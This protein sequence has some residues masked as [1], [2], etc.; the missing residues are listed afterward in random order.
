MTDGVK[1]IDLP[2]FP[3]EAWTF[4]GERDDEGKEDFYATVAAVFRATNLTASAT[5]NIPFALV[6]KSGKDYDV[7][8]EWENKILF[9]P[10]PK[11]L[12]RLWRL[13]L[14]M[15][16]EAYGFME[17]KKDIGKNLRYIVPTT[18]TPI[19]DNEKGL[20]GFKRTIG[21][22]SKDYPL[23]KNNP[24]FWMWRMDH[25]TE[26][27]PAKATEF[28]AMCAAAGILY[29]SDHFIEAF[30]KRGGIRPTMLVLKGMTTKEKVKDIEH[31]WTQIISGKFRELGKV[32]QGVEATGGLE[33][34]TIGEGVDTLKD[35][36][37]TKSKI[38]DVAMSIGMPLSLLLANSA[39]YATAL[40]EYKEW[41]ENSLA[42]WCDFMAE[43][44]TDKLFKPLGLRFEF[45]PEM[46]DPGQ[47]DEVA[48][49]SAYST[50][51]S[52]G[53]KP[54]VAAQVIGMELPDDIEYEDLDEMQEEKRQQ[55][56]ELAKQSSSDNG[57]EKPNEQVQGQGQKEKVS[58]FIP[59]LDQLHELET[60]RKF[61]FRKFKKGES[62][63]FP[64]EV[65]KLPDDIAENIRC[66]LEL[67]DSE[68][69]IKRAFELKYRSDQP[70][71]ESGRWIDESGNE[72]SIGEKI[73]DNK[74]GTIFKLESADN[75]PKNSLIAVGIGRNKNN[76]Y[77]GISKGD[78]THNR[79]IQSIN[80]NDN[81]DN[82]VRFESF[83]FYE[84][85]KSSLSV[86]I[87][88]AGI[89]IDE[90]FTEEKAMKNIYYAID[91]LINKGLPTDTIITIGRAGEPD[92]D[93]VAGKSINNTA[94]L[95][96]ADAINKACENVA[97][98]NYGD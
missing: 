98:L 16:N 93:I 34:Q 5:A 95:K 13:S 30:F 87:A 55:A 3:N 79:M 82:Y 76:I 6:D 58:K 74:H 52:S 69:A 17:N 43:E 75:L 32:F 26:L 20:I 19:T 25:T 37:L 49:A 2:Q 15:T 31:S 97:V 12:I 70:R 90:N 59:N 78:L 23:G 72:Y 47:E 73:L 35:E 39:N 41:Y 40:V 36:T 88:S 21:T 94:I 84:G 28:Q 4:Y 10:K 83:A 48:R 14:I 7:S 92:F 9:M 85:Q 57:K 11:E 61:A 45:R 62:L 27:L 81:V 53:I 18:I 56:I 71:D 24:I 22:G 29:Y 77:L 1:S 44:M 80:P 65:K 86:S 54:S 64:F 60:W 42:P 38:E 96:L 67:A 51:V 66:G 63:D 68:D 50:Y 33:A 46:T 89:P 8:T 91:K